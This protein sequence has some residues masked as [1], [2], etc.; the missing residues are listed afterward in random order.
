MSLIQ[1]MYDLNAQIAHD[2]NNFSLNEEQIF[3]N[4][5]ELADIIKNFEK[6]NIDTDFV[7]N[8]STFIKNLHVITENSINFYDE[9]M[10]V[11]LSDFKND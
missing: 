5:N 4:M 7:K 9:A 1:R 11:S 6:N 10:F 3:S 8:C 2:M